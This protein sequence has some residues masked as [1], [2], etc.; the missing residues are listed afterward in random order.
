MCLQNICLFLK[1]QCKCE[2]ESASDRQRQWTESHLLDEI[3]FTLC[4]PASESCWRATSQPV[5]SRLWL[6]VLKTMRANEIWHEISWKLPS[7]LYIRYNFYPKWLSAWMYYYRMNGQ[8]GLT[9]IATYN[10]NQYHRLAGS[11]W[12]WD[13]DLAQLSSSGRSIQDASWIKTHCHFILTGSESQGNPLKRNWNIYS[14]SINALVDLLTNWAIEIYSR[15]WVFS[16]RFHF[17]PRL[18][19]DEGN[20]C[21][22]KETPLPFAK[23]LTHFNSPL[24][25]PSH[26]QSV[27]SQETFG[28][29]R[30]SSVCVPRALGQLFILLQYQTLAQR[31]KVM[32]RKAENLAKLTRIPGAPGKDQESCW[33]W[34]GAPYRR[35]TCPP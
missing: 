1:R 13:S 16:R 35:F 7:Y 9:L 22:V 4:C 11:D 28:H 12:K 6:T 23:S 2:W 32:V 26:L 15:A 34:S 14:D 19:K 5:D 3:T 20:I 31:I 21:W 17:I 10:Y 29:R 27:S 24:S 18:P 8:I 25:S 33:C 30:K